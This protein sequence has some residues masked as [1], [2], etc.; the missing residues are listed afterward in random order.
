MEDFENSRCS[1]EQAAESLE[2]SCLD[3]A[4]SA[5]LSGNHT[6][7]AFLSPDKMTAFSR[8]S[9]FGMTFAPLTAD[10]GED[11]L[12]W[13]REGFLALTS[14]PPGPTTTRTAN[15]EESKEQAAAFGRKC[16]ES[17]ERCNLRL[18]LLKT[19]HN[20]GLADLALCC[21][22]LPRWGLML[23]GECWAVATSARIISESGFGSLLPTPTCHNAKEAAYRAEYTRSTPTLAAQIGGRI[24]PIW[25][26]FRMG[27]PLEWTRLDSK[28]LGTARFQAWS[29]SHGRR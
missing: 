24:N 21:E 19:P 17:L 22:T 25:N 6:P 7:Q 20:C 9:R 27:W 26:E 28:P 1:Q 2:E 4:Q 15:S 10:R 11:V 3:G 12:T 8:L 13:F 29:D 5:P 18:S 16:A 23:R 14:H